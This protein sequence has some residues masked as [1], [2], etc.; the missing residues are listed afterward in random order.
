MQVLSLTAEQAAARLPVHVQGVVTAAEP[1]W[2]GRFFI[3]DE[4][5]GVFVELISTNHPEPGDVV[6]V[7]GVTF[8]GAYAPIITGPV[9]KKTGAAPLPPAPQVPIERIM[10]GV[11][12]GQRVEV[13]GIVH[14]VASDQANPA[15]L[16]VDLNSSGYRIP[17]V[18]PLQHGIDPA[19]LIG[20]RVRVKG[21]AAATFNATLRHMIAVTLY[22]PRP[23]DFVIDALESVNPFNEA[24]M[25]LNS[26]AQY[27]RDLPPGRRVHVRGVVTL[28]RPGEDFFLEDKTGGLQVKC[29]QTQLLT[30]G[31]VVD[32]VGFPAFEGFLPVL[33]DALFLK[34]SE[35]RVPVKA[36]GVT[37][38]EI[39]DGLHH[40]GLVTLTAKVLDRNVQPG[41]LFSHRSWTQTTL[42]LQDAG[43]L[44]TAQ[45]ESPHGVTTLADIPIGSTIE[46]T[47][48]CFTETDADQHLKSLQILL[49]AANNVRILTKP[50]W[51]TPRRL[52]IVLSIL[53][54][55]LVVVV[56]L[57]VTVSKRNAALGRLVVEKERA[58]R[59]LQQAHDLLEDRVKER[60]AQLKFQIS[61]RKEAEV[62]FN[63]TLMERTRLAQ[64]LHDTLEQTLTGIGLQ[65]ATAAKLFQQK[66]ETA[67]HHLEQA[68]DQVAQSQ[69]EVRRSIW[70]LRSRALEQFDLPGALVT[71]SRQLA[72]AAD[73]HI[74]LTTE[75]RVR[76]LP[77]I[78]E[79]NLL[80]IGQEAI[81][82]VIKHSQA[83]TAEI[84][85]DYGPENVILRIKDNGRGFAREQCAG[86]A[87]GH[88][89][90]LGISERA[91][92][93]NAALTIQSSPGAGTLIMV[94]V[95]LHQETQSEE[96]GALPISQ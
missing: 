19:S 14:A 20:A 67:S 8:P 41:Q 1:G 79:D 23:A 35:P 15:S 38:Q 72:E 2:A 59:E 4:S 63:A 12:D 30:A 32:V 3:Q 34:T 5:S 50:S 81:T 54:A 24:T 7:T 48:V 89:G 25:P 86:P 31:D 74:E 27:R 44:F 88:F 51:L 91:K 10:S 21:T 45:A 96:G 93:L 77:E 37:M 16:A 53:F 40:A 33:E 9:W 76:P 39:Q 84:H 17:V 57:T 46:V 11:E 60:T 92:R 26:I 68:R 62:Q 43:Q 29:R 69:L 28:Q 87:D 83:T 94:Q 49:P 82:N 71:S 90:L 66:P 22:V 42:W 75:G 55:V 56:F 58:Q 36:R 13:D 52:L 85:L 73:I 47:G 70:N 95:G 80:R 65:L 64:E 78:V 6:E 18:S 61:A